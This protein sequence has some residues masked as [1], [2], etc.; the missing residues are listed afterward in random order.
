MKLDIESLQAFKTVIE[1]GSFTLA[2]EKLCLTQ[3]AVSWKLKRLEQRL[4]CLLLR[5]EGRHLQLTRQGRDLLDYAVQILAAHDAAVQRFSASDLSGSI[6]LGATDYITVEH[7]VSIAGQFRRM[8]PGIQLEIHVDLPLTLLDWL[9]HGR[10][11]LTILL[12]EEA[13]I[14]ATDIVL[15][16]D[17]LVWVQSRDENFDFSDSKRVPLVS[18]GEKCCLY[19]LAI[20]RLDNAAIAYDW[21]LQSPS[22]AGVQAAISE[23]LGITLLN[24]RVMNED[25]CE[26]PGASQL[27]PT[28]TM[29]YVIRSAQLPL[30]EPQQTLVDAI[31]AVVQFET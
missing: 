21:V 6:R 28:P 15:W 12:I 9:Q 4:G 17:E 31:G 19:Q 22:L 1:Q 2:A 27:L 24:R 29:A 7:L 23:G 10:V 3:S 5:R 18:F 13:D 20:N 8:H 30:P 11:D 14:R 16:R 25:Q 26:W